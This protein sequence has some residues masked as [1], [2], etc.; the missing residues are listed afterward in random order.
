MEDDQ[1]QTFL[2]A[3][4]LAMLISNRKNGIPMGVP[5]WFEWADGEVRMFAAVGSAKLRRL[6]RD[7]RISV[8]VTN[9]IGE[10]EHWVAFDGTVAVQEQDASG[11]I[12]RLGARYWNLDD[13]ERKETLDSW[14][15]NAAAFVTLTLTPDRIRSGS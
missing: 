8:L 13:P 10:P 1:L 6:E 4:R 9:H 15:A 5:V 11:L 7:P 2:E 3:P 14:V 12:A